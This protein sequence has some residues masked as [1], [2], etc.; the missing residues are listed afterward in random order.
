VN[1]QSE[2]TML[3]IQGYG[4][5]LILILSIIGA[6]LYPNTPIQAYTYLI[7]AESIT[8]G[9]GAFVYVTIIERIDKK[10]K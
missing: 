10:C 5:I 7:F 9:V 8:V 4:I 3:R 2:K 1:K 6:Y